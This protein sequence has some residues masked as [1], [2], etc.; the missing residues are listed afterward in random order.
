MT[1]MSSYHIDLVAFDFALERLR[2]LALDDPFAELRGHRRDL[3]P[4]PFRFV[5]RRD[6]THEIDQDT[7]AWNPG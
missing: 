3:N 6:S 4:T 2:G 7:T 5:H 1:F